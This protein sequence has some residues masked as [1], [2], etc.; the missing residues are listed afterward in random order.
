VS[1]K[2]NRG[3]RFVVFGIGI[4]TMALVLSPPASASLVFSATFGSSITGNANKTE[5]ESAINT[6]L[7][8]LEALY[9]NNVTVPVTFTYTSGA[10]GDLLS[11]NQEFYD[12][13][14]SSY[15]SLLNADSAA[16]PNNLILASAVTNL[17]NGNDSN[18]A[19]DMALTA[20]QI[21]MLSG[22][23]YCGGACTGGI[24]ININSNQNFSFSEPTS[25]SQF[26]L[27]G[28][29]E[30]ELDETLGGG[31]G[32]STLDSI[33]G[34]CTTAPSGF[35]CNKYGA[36]DLLR[37]SANLTP[38]FATSGSASSYLSVNGGLTSIVAFNQNSSGDYGDFA[39]PGTGAGQLIQDAFNT[40]GQDETYTTS[41]PEYTMLE[42][43]GWDGASNVPEPGT[44]VL[45]GAGLALI[46]IARRRL[47]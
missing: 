16:H 44:I 41:S 47:V 14:Y 31:G 28:G 10:S 3:G 42:A 38:S 11:T 9:V 25:S 22:N 23:T 32:G 43:I 33:A 35:F 19:G 12:I 30:H 7:Q 40:T 29:L 8:N 37:Y 4:A 15:V 27:I 5:I 24:T 39:P 46:G 17:P 26:D 21:N 36:T 13:G 1:G 20:A 18:G 34:S 45:V 6:A 2:N